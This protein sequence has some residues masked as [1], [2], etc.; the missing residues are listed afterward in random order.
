MAPLPADDQLVRDLRAL[1]PD[2]RAA[3]LFGSA[4]S[5]RL[6][7]DSDIDVAVRVA[8]PLDAWARYELI[9]DLGSRWKRDV[10]LL[11]FRRLSPLMQVQVLQGRKLFDDEPVEGHLEVARALRQWQDDEVRQKPLR[12]A[13]MR[14][15][16]QMGRAP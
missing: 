6:R 14:R 15:L 7:P 2:A 10:D 16:Q 11:D 13:L 1:L 12:R 4:A 8:D 5:G 3:W 9:A